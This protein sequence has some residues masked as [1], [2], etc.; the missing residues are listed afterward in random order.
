MDLARPE[1][2]QAHLPSQLGVRPAKL[3]LDLLGGDLD[4]ELAL[5]RGQLF[6]LDLHRRAGP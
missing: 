6:D 3:G 2:R 1:T 4:G 5:D